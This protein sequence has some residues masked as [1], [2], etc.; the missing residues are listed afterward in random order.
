MELFY[1]YKINVFVASEG[2]VANVVS[3]QF[4]CVPDFSNE[5]PNDTYEFSLSLHLDVMSLY[6]DERTH[7]A[8]DCVEP[9]R[10]G[11]YVRTQVSW[12]LNHLMPSCV[13]DCGLTHCM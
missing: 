8:F 6:S 9:Q 13:S 12:A 4:S 1:R 7:D 2:S 10:V 11:P 3:A 5:R